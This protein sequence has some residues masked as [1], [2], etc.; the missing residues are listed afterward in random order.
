[1]D[2]EADGTRVSRSRAD[3]LASAP[4]YA[5]IMAA[6]AGVTALS[7]V[8]RDTL[9]LA[10][11]TMIYLL[12]VLIVAITTGTAAA[13]ISALVSFVCI[14]FFL[15]PP[16]YSLLVADPREFLDLVVFSVVA[17]IAG[18]LGAQVRQR[19]QEAHQRAREQ[20]ILY[21][22]TRTFNQLVDHDGV[23]QALTRVLQTE[24]NAAQ[25]SILPHIPA[26]AASS[27]TE[28]YLLLQ[29]AERIYAT[30]HIV[31]K[32]PLTASQTALV[33]T[34]VSQASLVLQRV[35]LTERAIKSQQF[36]Q[37]DKLKTAILQAVSHDLRTPITIIRTSASNLRQFHEQLSPP[38]ER[39]IA[40]VIEQEATT[41]DRLVGN[42]L[43]MS[44]LQAGALTLNHSLND[45]EEIAGDVAAEMWQRSRQ[46]RVRLKFP[47]DLPLVWSDYGLLR[48]AISN[49]VEN[50]VRYE[51]ANTQVE[52]RAV[53]HDGE[54]R[55]VIINHGETID[56]PVKDDIMKPFY[57]GHDGH[58]GLG[59]P[60][61][62]GIIE[63]HRGRLWVEDTPG[64]GATFI[65]AL[66]LGK[67]QGDE[68]DDSGRR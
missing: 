17:V 19:S 66:P 24:M 40:E 20:E 3:W 23:Y 10:N 64:G 14:N 38:E 43:D 33:N 59:L 16:Y 61:A 25:A 51:P 49:I 63:A 29:T 42:L 11:F 13:A 57:R 60:I 1:M 32:A 36:E 30:V 2:R 5:A 53:V 50:T 48:Q 34:C 6:I 4:T 58:I 27:G 62:K 31:F 45:L 7:F 15:V 46:E 44:R 8:L 26:S 35:D 21:H 55:I 39:E 12:V 37:A 22:V 9:T 47:D 54:F 18:Q 68:T 65:I 41:L 28:Y 52:I 56:D 67:E